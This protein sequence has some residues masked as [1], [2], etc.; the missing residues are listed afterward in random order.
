[1]KRFENDR[2]HEFVAKR[3]RFIQDKYFNETNILSFDST[4]PILVEASEAD[5]A[6]F[7]AEELKINTYYDDT[8]EKDVHWKAFALI[9]SVP[10]ATDKS[11]NQAIFRVAEII[12]EEG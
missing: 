9:G 7:L 3:F 10:A 8:D 5:V 11:R 4:Y 12:L 2:L 6:S 1:M